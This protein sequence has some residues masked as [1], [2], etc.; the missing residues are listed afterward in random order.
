MATSQFE[1]SRRTHRAHSTTATKCLR[2]EL[3]AR[4]PEDSARGSPVQGAG[5]VSYNGY[6]LYICMYYV[7]MC[8]CTYGEVAC[9][10]PRPSWLTM[11]PD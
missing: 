8:G 5:K 9:G 7:C 1:I 10:L 3:S 2:R 4:A 6:G 11:P